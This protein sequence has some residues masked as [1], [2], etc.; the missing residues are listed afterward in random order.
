[1]SS[2]K[3]KLVPITLGELE[4]SDSSS[5]WVLNVS[6]P[7]GNINMDIPDGMGNRTSIRV[8]I[9]FIPVDL[10]TQATKSALLGNPQFRSMLAK[11]MMMLVTADSANDFLTQPHAAEEQARIY[12]V[13]EIA[14]IGS[15]G[16]NAAALES[17]RAESEGTIDPF[18]LNIAMVSDQDEDDIIRQLRTRGSQLKKADWMHISRT[19]KFEK[20]KAFAASEALDADE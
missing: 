6:N 19:S 16:S 7:Q 4:K 10:T 20:V 18:A 11:K 2:T 9:T 5:V 14:E 12:S 15:A 17:L 1:M 8:P 3:K 13:G